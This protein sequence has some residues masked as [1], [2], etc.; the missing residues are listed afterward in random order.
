MNLTDEIAEKYA[1]KVVKNEMRKISR[2]VYKAVFCSFREGLMHNIDP[3][4]DFC[5]D[6]CK[7]YKTEFRCRECT[8]NEFE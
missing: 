6:E 8:K 4:P 5:R 7:M 3:T 2:I 1:K